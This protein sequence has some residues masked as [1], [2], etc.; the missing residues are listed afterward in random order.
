LDVSV[1]EMSTPATSVA[2]HSSRLMPDHFS[3]RTASKQ[4]VTV[5]ASRYARNAEL[6]SP[7][8]N[9]SLSRE[10]AGRKQ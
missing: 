10:S 4:T 5:M 7:T 1:K 9:S 8:M 3:S 6:S 2:H